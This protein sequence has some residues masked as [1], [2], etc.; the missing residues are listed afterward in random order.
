M[1]QH[2]VLIGM[3][4]VGKTTVGRLLARK[5]GRPFLDTDQEIVKREGRSIE[6]IFAVSGE[7]GFRQIETGVLQSLLEMP[8][9]TVIATGGGIVLREENRALLR[10]L[11]YTIWLQ[12][13]A[14]RLVERLA[15][16]QPQMRPLLFREDW[17]QVV[18]TLMKQRQGL[19]QTVA[20]YSVAV[21]AKS[22]LQIVQ[23]ICQI[24]R[25]LERG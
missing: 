3:M 19:Y 14:A 4:G 17:P 8:Q 13:D 2:I 22:P 1:Y 7:E 16:S 9:P 6:A 10:Q 24:V 12:L 23:E 21:A 25:V 20:D 5:L 11:G 18:A 15:H